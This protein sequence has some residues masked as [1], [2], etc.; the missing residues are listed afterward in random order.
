MNNIHL[1]YG[2]EDFLIHE[3]KGELTKNHDRLQIS[4]HNMRETTVQTVVEDALTID[5]FGEEKLIVLDDCAFLT[6]ETNSKLEHDFDKL[7]SYL[8]NP[9]DRTQLIFIVHAEKL[10]KRKK[11]VKSL[12]KVATTFEAKPNHYPQ[13]WIQNQATFEGKKI[14]REAADMLVQRLG[15]NLYLL[16]SEIKKIALFIEEETIEANMIE[17]IISRTLDDDVFKL[18]D[19][20]VRHQKSA[21]DILDDLYRLGEEPIAILLLIARQLRIIHQVKVADMQG[22]NPSSYIKLHPYALKMAEE[23]ALLYDI[24]TLQDMLKSCAEL[25]LKMKRGQVQKKLALELQIIQWL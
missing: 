18:V 7:L 19:R 3:K 13:K 24:Q 5:L 15:T 16:H 17:K 12:L 23:Q 8:A 20:V 6:G 21:L 9:N 1:L 4:T 2:I 22:L 25:D 14:T 11:I 10:D